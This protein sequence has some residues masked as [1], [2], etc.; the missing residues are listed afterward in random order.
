M[1]LAGFATSAGEMSLS[2]VIGPADP[3]KV[4][5]GQENAVAITDAVNAM[6]AAAPD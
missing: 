1:T 2:Q 6:V 4:F 3:H 5:D